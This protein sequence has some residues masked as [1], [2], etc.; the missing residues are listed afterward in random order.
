MRLV[1]NG[2][3]V[4]KVTA[5]K[6]PLNALT[7]STNPH[8]SNRFIERDANLIRTIFFMAIVCSSMVLA[9]I[10]AAWASCSPTAGDN[11]GATCT[12]TTTTQYG[13]GT[14]TDLSVTVSSG[15]SVAVT[16]TGSTGAQSIYFSTGTVNN[17]GTLAAI[18]DSGYAE[19]VHGTATATVVNSG[20]ISAMS[21][22]YVAYGIQGST[23][24]TVTNSGTISASSTTSQAEGVLSD[25]AT[26][27]NSGSISAS[28]TDGSAWGIYSSTANVTNSGSISAFSYANAAEGI[29][30]DISTVTNSGAI[31]AASSGGY[32]VYGISGNTTA[33]VANSG[34]I[35]ASGFADTAGIYGGSTATVMN[36]GSIS[37]SST[38]GTAYAIFSG[39]AT[40]TNSSTISALSTGGH[41][42]GIFS[43]M[44]VNLTNSGTIYAGGAS[45]VI[46]L[47]RTGVYGADAA[48]VN[49]SGT[50][51]AYND[52]ILGGSFGISADN[53]VSINNSGT[54]SA[55]TT[56]HNTSAFAVD[57]SNGATSL[58]TVINSGKIS[59]VGTGASGDTVG[60]SAANA[61]ISNSGSISA[62]GTNDTSASGISVTYNT[63]KVTNSGTISASSETNSAEGVY[64]YDAANVYNTGT[65]LVST[66]SGD[67]TVISGDTSVTVSNSGTMSASSIS[68]TAIGIAGG[69]GNNILTNTGTISSTTTSGTAYAIQFGSS[70]DTVTLGVG[71]EIIGAIDLGGGAD[72][73]NFTGGNSNLTFTSGNLT[74]AV[75]TGS[76]IPY[77][78]SGDRAASVDPTSF[79]SSV[80]TLQSTTRSV[81]SIVPDFGSTG[82]EQKSLPALA[83]TADPR[84]PNLSSGIAAIIVDKSKG[85]AA[86][87]NGKTSIWTRAFGGKSYDKADGTLVSVSDIYYGG[88]VGLDR[89]I[90]PTLNYGAYVGGVTA[91]STLGSSY[92]NIVTNMAVAGGYA[93]QAWGATFVKLGFQSGYGTN[94]STRYT[95]NNLLTSGVE[96]ATASYSNWYLS[97][98][99]SAGHTYSLGTVLNG[100]VALTPV[101]QARYVYGSFGSYTESGGT[102]SF[103]VNSHSAQSVEENLSVKASHVS[104][105]MPGYLLR[106][107]ITGGILA[108]Q[109]VKSDTISASLLGQSISF[110]QPGSSTHTGAKVG[111]G[112]ELTNGKISFSAGGDYIAQTGGNYDYS[113]RLDVNV[114]F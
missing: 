16:E 51:S 45:N 14:E 24:A 69:A 36:S 26:V 114:R 55:I 94:S 84:T 35:S 10:D 86:L 31:S 97:P 71:S 91:T 34:S 88:A 48:I 64:S 23:T 56:G 96:T 103:S 95:N 30:G 54:I 102:D 112:A 72:V 62:S 50:I 6:R 93:R 17:S 78:V 53:N 32:F 92:G 2:F 81:S 113:G 98:E 42:Y 3:V 25:T 7:H 61:D 41:S 87:G 76:T 79:A 83:Y 104:S 99:L 89:V 22:S 8:Q 52:S 13:A 37:A 46:Y 9:N 74:S 73:V 108:S 109:N 21:S 70:V 65:I 67:A 15:A 5:R 33:S 11:V 63:A 82:S 57:A 68:G 47:Y 100:D 1:F 43:S 20:S 18:A 49:N 29:Y 101:A 44:A 90:D 58:A 111:L 110:S 106:L 66:T 27:T 77:A 12:G 75:F 59:V 60:I 105:V 39:T 40:V 80:N 38:N 107:D 4:E 85:N 28:S 19:G